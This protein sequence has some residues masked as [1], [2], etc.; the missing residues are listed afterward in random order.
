[1]TSTRLA[2]SLA[3][4][5][6]AAAGAVHLRAGARERAAEAAFPPEGRFVTVGGR[7]VHAVVAGDGPEVVLIHGLSGNARDFT[8]AL[9]PA[10]A[11]RYRVIAFDRPGL[12]YS[13]AL[14]PG[15]DGLAEQAAVLQQAAALLGA[16]RPL[17]V[18]Q[19]YGG[20]VGLAWAV[21]RPGT[22][23]ALVTVGA[24]SHVWEGGMSAFYR[25]TAPPLGAVLAVP[26]LTALAPGAQVRQ[27]TESVFAPQ[28]MP[29]GYAEHLGAPLTLRRPSLRANA[30][31]RARLKADLAAL[32]PRYPDLTLPVEV[33]HGTA[34]QT[35]SPAI[36][37][38][39][40]AREVA[41]A[42][43]TLLPGQGHMPHHTAQA[44]VLAAIDR[45]AERA[46][47]RRGRHSPYWRDG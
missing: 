7:R 38:E 31:H 9:L 26:L 28:P 42:R 34:D 47:L 8:F 44:E 13:D 23:A 18:G 33:L 24:P 3:L 46:G 19:S 2:A 14:P 6:I 36:H 29:A 16:A 10:L 20:S 12:G 30:R 22:L 43:L 11:R 45:A 25:I 4:L 5:L 21:E 35:V 27:A 39:A 17:V 32:V 41:S 40:F 1:M 37:A 15:A